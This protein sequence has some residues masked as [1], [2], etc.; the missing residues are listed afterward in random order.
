M[1]ENAKQGSLTM[2]PYDLELR[3]AVAARCISYIVNLII[4]WNMCSAKKI[5]KSELKSITI[6][7]LYLMRCG[8][9]YNV[10]IITQDCGLTHILPSENLLMP[11]FEFKSK[12]ITD[13]I[14]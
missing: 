12:F 11:F 8:V 6:G 9:N 14:A 5:R 7:I 4:I 10:V 13:T 2:H 3:E 1:D